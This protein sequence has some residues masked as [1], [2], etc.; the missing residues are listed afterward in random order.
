[1]MG[2]CNM[3]KADGVCDFDSQPAA[4]CNKDRQALETRPDY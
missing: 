2:T 4:V 1:M 3:Q